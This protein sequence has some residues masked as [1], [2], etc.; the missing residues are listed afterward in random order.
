VKLVKSITARAIFHR[1]PAVT[2]Q[3]WGGEFWSKGYCIS[4][5]GRY[6]NAE[7][8]RQYVKKPGQEQTYQ[9]WHRQDVQLQLF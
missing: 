5:V 7:A 8:I 1:V 9:Q 2:K 3:L 4:T 6:G